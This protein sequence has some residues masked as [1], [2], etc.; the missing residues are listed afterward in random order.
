ME[1]T[2]MT[3]IGALGMC[4]LMAAPLA[5][6][7]D[8][9]E[10]VPE[11]GLTDDNPAD[12]INE[13]RQ[14]HVQRHDLEAPS[15]G[16]AD[17]DHILVNVKQRH[18]YEG[19]LITQSSRLDTDT[20]AGCAT[21][22]HF[23][24]L[25]GGGFAVVQESS[26][27]TGQPGINTVRF[28]HTAADAF[29]YLRVTGSTVNGN[30]AATDIYEIEFFDTTYFVPRW[31]NA[32]GQVTV[33]LIQDDTA[34]TVSGSVFFYNP[35]GTLL[36]TEPLSVGVYGLRS[37]NTSAIPALAGFSGSATVAHTGGWGALS[38]K[39]VALD[40]STGFSFDTPFQFIPR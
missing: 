33:F 28:I 2:R 38:G 23:D 6:A 40:P 25:D 5:M 34:A 27:P 26:R 18:S 16:A 32:G 30:L 36:H 13:L 10:E 39:A 14:G 12:Q 8:R 17:L 19:R 37:I 11:Y 7:H 20:A 35:A 4:L 31:N 9:W 15:A 29:Q 3:T 21:C 22:A 24:R 1:T